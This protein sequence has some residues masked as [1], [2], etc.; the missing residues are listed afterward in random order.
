LKKDEAE[1]KKRIINQNKSL[2]KG[3]WF[4][5]PS[6]KST[7][8]TKGR[9]VGKYLTTADTS[10]KRTLSLTE[11]VNTQPISKKYTKIANKEDKFGENW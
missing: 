9:E 6:G 4:S 1:E 3:Q 10:K 11:P 5:N 8:P 2:E 7:Q